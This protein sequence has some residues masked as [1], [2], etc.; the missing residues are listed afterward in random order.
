MSEPI[1]HEPASAAP[2]AAAGHDPHAQAH[3]AP[4]AHDAHEL[5]H[6]KKHIRVY[7]MVFG[8]LLVLTVVTVLA[9]YFHFGSPESNV[10]NIAVALVIASVKASLVAMFFM[11]LASE[12][13]T[14]YRFLIVT[15]IFAFALYALTHLHYWDQ[16][17][18]ASARAHAEQQH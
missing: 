7:L 9:S 10:G 14:I 1:S 12:K 16:I 3:D 6:L 5:E 15:V 8:A 18:A 4:H 17:G 13:W 11:H 2:S